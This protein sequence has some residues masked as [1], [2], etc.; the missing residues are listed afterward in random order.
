MGLS[1]IDNVRPRYEGLKLSQMLISEDWQ[2]GLSR[3]ATDIRLEQERVDIQIPV[4]R[5]ETTKSS[6]MQTEEAPT[7]EPYQPLGQVALQP[8]RTTFLRSGTGLL[9]RQSASLSKRYIPKGGFIKV[10]EEVTNDVPKKKRTV[11]HPAMAK[12]KTLNNTPR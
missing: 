10:F 3:H 7:A 4:R 5:L 6:D 12:I 2:K 1:L 9:N 11:K 8:S